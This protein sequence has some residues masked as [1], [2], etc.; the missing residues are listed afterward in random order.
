[1]DRPPAE[2]VARFQVGPEVQEDVRADGVSAE[3]REVE[4][5]EAVLRADRADRAV[6]AVEMQSGRRGGEEGGV[7]GC[8]AG[9]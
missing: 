5:S 8:V 7:A 3:D 6:S 2:L 4:R 9:R 1:M